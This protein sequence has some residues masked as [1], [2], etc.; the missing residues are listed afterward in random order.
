MYPRELRGLVPFE[1]AAVLVAAL[2]PL[3]IPRVVPLLIAASASR[4]AR[5]RSWGDVARVE[6]VYA[7]VGAAAGAAALGLALVIGAP[8]IEALTERAVSWSTFP[9]VR[10][11][12]NQ[13]V[14]VAVVVGV[15]AVAAELALRGWLVE[16]VLELGRGSPALAVLVGALAEAL[17]VDG[18]LTA[19]LGAVAF[20]AGLG[21][22]YVA[23][24]RSVTAPICARLV[25]QLGALLLEAMRVVG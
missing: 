5:G 6:P 16:R 23:G 12:A 18:E 1:V 13:L 24:G 7:A 9:I 10:G 3:P 4:W 25:F 21:W 20:G 17:L 2:V 15:T 11:S 19:R 14:V 8:L 22:M